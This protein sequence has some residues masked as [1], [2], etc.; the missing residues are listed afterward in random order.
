MNILNP[1]DDGLNHDLNRNPV[2]D[3]DRNPGFDSETYPGPALNFYVGTALCSDA[4]R[5]LVLV[6]NSISNLAPFSISVHSDLDSQFCS[7]SR[8][9]LRLR[10]GSRFR[11]G[12]IGGKY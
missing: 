2:H 4:S 1:T 6:L 10:C 9:R 5:V 7:P 3:S 12:R 11:F 8:F